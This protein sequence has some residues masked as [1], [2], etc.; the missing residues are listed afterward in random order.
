MG[1]T[2]STSKQTA[3]AIRAQC[4][5]D[6]KPSGFDNRSE[7]INTAAGLAKSI[8]TNKVAPVV[9]TYN[10]KE[11]FQV[12]DDFHKA[13]Y[14]IGC[15]NDNLPEHYLVQGKYFMVK[16]FNNKVDDL[17]TMSNYGAPNFRQS[18][19]GYPVYG[20]GQPTMKGFCK[21]L[22]RLKEEGHQEIICFNVREEPI[23]LFHQDD[24][25]IPYTPRDQTNLQENLY[26]LT[27]R[28]QVE[29]LELIIKKE[30]LDFAALSN[31]TYFVYND[32]EQF[33]AEALPKKIE[34]EDDI[35][36]SE[37]IYRCHIFT[38]PIFRYKRLPLP[39]DTNLEEADFDDFISTVRECPS[40]TFKDSCKSPPA[41]LFNCQTGVGRSNLG[42]IIGALIMAHRTTFPQ[43]ERYEKRS[44]SGQESHFQIVESYS[45]SF[46][47]GRK[48]V[49]EVD[50]IMNICS[51]MYDLKEIIYL[52]KSKA[53]KL[54]EELQSQEISLR[55][56][57]ISKAFQM[58]QRYFYL[59]AFNSYLH[60][61]YPLAFSVMFST[62]MRRKPFFYRLL[63]AM[64]RLEMKT[65]ANPISGRHCV[66]FADESLDLDEMS[67]LREMKVANYRK[68]SKMPV[69]GM[70]QPN[71]EGLQHI[72]SYLTDDCRKFSRVLCL[73]LREEAVLEGDGKMY[74]LR[75]VNSLQQEI[76]IPVTTAE[77]LEEVET[78]TK[79]DVLSS[80]NAVETWHE[81][82]KQLKQFAS[83]NTLQE[84]YTQIA[85]Q[86]PQ[87]HYKRIPITDC[88]APR[89]EDFD[90]F[91]RVVKSHLTTHQNCAIILNCHNGK[92]RTTVG[93]VICLLLTWHI[94]GFP[95]PFVEDMVSIPDAKYT[96][97]E[98]EA[99]LNLVRLLPNGNEMKKEVDRA[100]DA[101][102]DSMTPMMHHLRELIIN[103]YKKSKRAKD[104]DSASS[105]HLRSLQY[106][107]RYFYLILF[108]TYLHLEKPGKWER[109]FKEWMDEV[110]APAGVF[111]ILDKL[112]FPEFEDP[113]STSMCRMR[114]RWRQQQGYKAPSFGE[115]IE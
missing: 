3:S 96:K 48:I 14:V 71:P 98:F 95:E 67:S 25:F 74:S 73:N 50:S 68:V 113:E 33:V 37:E 21:V 88:A 90:A 44:F 99:I 105:L 57:L 106:L 101:V 11:E 111:E 16:D 85:T 102:S 9:I 2:A 109:S 24:D 80:Q 36:L 31:K 69:C 46:P 104:K 84:V 35:R 86:F 89:E 5:R 115:M 112:G 29:E 15:M 17:L 20:M 19:L 53:Q 4:D 87:L 64:S 7:D 28:N 49:E 97:G 51:E 45:A 61:Q 41:L 39:V 107:E 79:V 6:A 13:H 83:C 38:M 54:A 1:T 114:Y 40:L 42:M 65:P 66:L 100:L 78:A 60:E 63:S 10:L 32:T 76:I 58:I 110:A 8:I 26:S 23:I 94:N 22:Q 56:N 34:N 75:E 93:M 70:A 82:T 59:I 47:N 72:L 103:T 108:D 62:W 77:Q 91:L 81:E 52:S 55:E 12:H 27:P 18:Y 30:L 43:L 92:R